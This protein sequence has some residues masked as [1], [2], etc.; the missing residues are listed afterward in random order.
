[1]N[2]SLKVQASALPV[3]RGHCD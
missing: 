1:M 3:Q 2:N